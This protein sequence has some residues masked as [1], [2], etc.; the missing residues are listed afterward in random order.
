MENSEIL[1][2]YGR[3]VVIVAIGLCGVSLSATAVV[4]PWL[5]SVGL[6]VVLFPA[7]VAWGGFRLPGLVRPEAK[8]LAHGFPPASGSQVTSSATS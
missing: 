5:Q 2:A 3:K 7:L 6:A 4:H 1:S 8:W